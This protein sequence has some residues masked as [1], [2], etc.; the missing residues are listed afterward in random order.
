M[1]SERSL[2]RKIQVIL[3]VARTARVATVKELRVQVAD[4]N[5]STFF[6]R[7]YDGEK[8]EFVWRM[9][10][11]AVQG[12]VSLCVSLT[13]IDLSGHLTDSGRDALRRTRFDE[14]IAVRVRAFLKAE[15]VDFFEL[16]RVVKRS[17]RAD[18]VV[19]PTA[20]VLWDEGQLRLGYGIFSKMLTLLANCGAVESTQRKVFLKLE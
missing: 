17:L 10:T 8:D 1:P 11:R 6:S 2:Y 12:A 7:Q 13:L 18:P 16:D 9:S 19:L 5:I 14:V 20:R 4:Q 3:E 15:G